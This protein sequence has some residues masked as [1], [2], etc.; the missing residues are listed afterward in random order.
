MSE[1]TH[2]EHITI[3]GGEYTVGVGPV[4][5]ALGD[6]HIIAERGG[7]VDAYDDAVVE[8]KRGSSI[9]VWSR[10]VTVRKENGARVSNRAGGTIIDV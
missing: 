4:V 7:R 1:L 9:Y 10:A 2:S 8:A 3:E 6:S 5:I